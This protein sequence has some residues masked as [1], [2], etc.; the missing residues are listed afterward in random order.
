MDNHAMWGVAEKHCGCLAAL[1]TQESRRRYPQEEDEDRLMM[2]N[3]FQADKSKLLKSKTYRVLQE[4]TQV[5]SRPDSALVRT[6]MTH[7]MEVVANCIDASEM[8]GLNTDLVEAAAIGHDVGHVPY[9]HPGEEWMKK[10]LPGLDNFCHEKMGVITTQKI[11]RAGRGLNLC[12]HTLE[13]MMCHSGNMAREGMS[14]EAWVVNYLDKITYLFHDYNDIYHTT[15]AHYPWKPAG[16]DDLVNSFG[17]NQRERTNTA[18]AGLVIESAKEGRVSFRHS[19]LAQR[20]QELRKL[21]YEVYFRVTKQDVDRLM[22][23]TYEFFKEQNIADPVL[24]L[25]LSTDS[26]V[27]NIS[28]RSNVNSYDF[29]RT[30]VSEIV[31]R[32]EKIQKRHGNINLCDPDLAW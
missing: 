18:I 6:R 10:N 17:D 11:E 20:F 8:L 31:D 32:F 19:N 25:A 3:P 24:L 12:W 7:V 13:A 16:L 21:M 5:F 9:G 29:K 2:K 28:A 4:K 22:R 23:P 26:D 30:T 27:Y 15:R 14:Q 1:K